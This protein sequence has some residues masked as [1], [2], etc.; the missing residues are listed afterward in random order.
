MNAI[1]NEVPA[2]ELT[3]L[4]REI[5][6][7][8]EQEE[9]DHFVLGGKFRRARNIC[10]D[11]NKSAAEGVEG[12]TGSHRFSFWL[13]ECKIHTLKPTKRKMCMGLY[14]AFGVGNPAIANWKVSALHKILRN[15][16]TT[17]MAE[18]IVSKHPQGMSNKEIDAL[19]AEHKPKAANDDTTE[20]KTVTVT[21]E[22][23][24]PTEEERAAFVK[25]VSS[26]LTPKLVEKWDPED[27]LNHLSFLLSTAQRELETELTA[28]PTKSKREVV[29]SVTRVGGYL[30]DV[31]EQ[32]VK[33]ETTKRLK[34]K[35]A[36]VDAELVKQKGLTKDMAKIL[37]TPF[38]KKDFQY[39][40]G[41]L[42]SDR[43][44]ADDRR[45]TAFSLFEK[46]KPLFGETK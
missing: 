41:V 34:A 16:A 13:N 11:V 42:H 26:M 40:R 15:K 45:N 43:P 17:H 25:R 1:I 12:K 33:A 24:V 20:D 35:E 28:L 27:P 5:T 18:D 4:A 46:L 9:K 44:V 23:T 3:T 21:T 6:E 38:A 36:K 30:A 7:I 19:L 29:H 39:I 37:K 8:A 14:D 31:F 22:L 10:D 32:H 2:G